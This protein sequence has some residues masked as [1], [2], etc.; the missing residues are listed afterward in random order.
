MHL[1]GHTSKP[2]AVTASTK[3]M[4]SSDCVT[5][6]LI[7]LQNSSPRHLPKNTFELYCPISGMTPRF[8]CY[9]CDS[10]VNSN[11]DFLKLESEKPHFMWSE[12]SERLL[13]VFGG[14]PPKTAP[15]RPVKSRQSCRICSLSSDNTL[16]YNPFLLRK[17]TSA[18]P[19]SQDRPLRP[20]TLRTPSEM[21]CLPA[22][23]YTG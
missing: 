20:V 2:V 9:A 10:T 22:G 12:D 23:I 6:I 19:P 8:V 4:H 11:E 15:V 18:L 13:T 5:E 3:L 7:R 17:D 14:Y 16:R 21:Q 1:S